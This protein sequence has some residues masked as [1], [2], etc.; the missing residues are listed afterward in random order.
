MK[1][2]ADGAQA[3]HAPAGSRIALT[4]AYV[5]GAD[6]LR[7]PVR[8]TVDGKVVIAEDD[9]ITAL[10]GQGGKISQSKLTELRG[11]NFAATF[12]D[13][14]GNPFKAPAMKIETFGLLLDVIPS[15]PWLLVELK[16]PATPAARQQ[17]VS[18]VMKAARNRGLDDRLIVY[19]TDPEALRDTRNVSP[20]AVVASYAPDRPAEEQLDSAIEAGSDAVVLHLPAVLDTSS[21]T[22][23]PTPLA[24][25]IT[26]RMNSKKLKLGAILLSTPDSTVDAAGLKLLRS[27]GAIWG[28]VTPSIIA[29]TSVLRPGWL[30]IDEKWTESADNH[31]DV[32]ADLWH[33]G[34]AKYN[35]KR[36]THVYPDDGIH[37]R[38]SPFTGEVT[39]E[40]SGDRV[41]DDMQH[42]LERSWDTAKDWPFYSGGGVGFAPGIEGDFS[43]EVDIQ[44]DNAQQ[45][46]TVEMAAVNVDPAAHRKPWVQDPQGNWQPNYPTS[47]RD[48]HSFFD[49]HGAPPFC[50]VEHDENDG[51]RINWNTGTDYDSNQYGKPWGDGTILKGRI[52][53][54]RRGAWFAAY[55]RPT[56]KTSARDWVCVGVARNQTLNARVYLRLVGKRWR[57]EDPNDPSTWMPVIPNHFVFRNITITRYL[58]RPQSDESQ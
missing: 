29:N 31:E 1:I 7:I 56:D 23:R 35:P 19:S 33:L 13:A 37:I 42:L 51:W 21:G 27:S 32:N 15:E 47:F 39:Y 22:P 16:S 55:F 54:D 9:N 25:K 46:T 3:A 14:S 10:A 40:P 57:Q 18:H 24:S 2:A 52:R 49:P 34:Y 20:S 26:E 48:K 41:R 11:L 53:L 50:G 17:L 30:W 5:G 44:S 6:M 4:S 36:Y 12:C 28:L 45:A 43:I 8:L 58:A 38:I